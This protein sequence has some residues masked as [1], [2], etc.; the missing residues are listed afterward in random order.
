MPGRALY[1]VTIVGLIATLLPSSRAG[2]EP[3]VYVTDFANDSVVVIDT[4]TDTV[5]TS[6]DIGSVGQGIAFT[7]DG[8]TAYVPMDSGDIAVIDVA[9]NTVLTNIF[10]G[11]TVLGLG[12]IAITPDGTTAYVAHEGINSVVVLDTA[13]N[14]VA[15]TILVGSTPREIAISRDGTTAYVGDRSSGDVYL[16]DVA[17]NTVATTVS[18]GSS[19]YGIAVTP[20]GAFV[21]VTAAVGSSVEVID[22]STNTVIK[23]IPVGSFPRTIAMTPDGAFVYAAN[24]TAAS[25]SVIDTSSNT[26]VTTVAVGSSPRGIAVT[27]DGASVYVANSVSGSVSVIDTATN[28]TLTAVATGGVPLAVAIAPQ[29]ELA[30]I[31][32]IADAS[33]DGVPDI[34]GFIEGT[35]GRPAIAAYSGAD[36]TV[37]ATIDYINDKWRG[38]A[39]ATVRDADQD[40][41]DDDPAAAMLVVNKTTGKIRVETRRVDTG[42][43][44]G[45]I[46]FFN[47]NWRAVDVVA[48]DD[49]NGDGSTNDTAIAVLAERISDGRIQLQLRDYTAGTLISNTVYLNARW[50][51]IAT[52]VVDRTEVAPAG[53]LSPLIGVIAEKPSDGRR[54]MQSRV[55]GSG[56]FERNVKFLGSTWDYLDMSVNHDANSDGTN[57]DPIWIVLAT[58]PSD[59]VIR[60]Q[61][62][63]VSDGSFDRNIVIL[64]SGWEAFR[65]DAANDMG[66]NG[67]GEMVISAERR[68]DDVRRIHVKDYASSATTLNIAP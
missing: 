9:S 27:P 24:N 38:A 16:I 68:A 67:S 19:A 35:A 13:T 18:V 65:L 31:S 47:Q 23:S 22:T 7:P 21:Y 58:R 30:D 44:L 11:S 64:N 50:T 39:L 62:R 52:A 55:A 36:G 6:I 25:V 42:A 51:P 14:T 33:G 54:V 57:D 45:S 43:F 17:S 59:D 49:L 40:G 61:S 63:F 37:F 34:T 26:V 2:A 10:S 32:S 29:S 1:A 48:V 56:A 66:G 60:V 5:I 8:D 3:V 12:G 46:Q 53:T 20:D 4:A 28:T 41:T 15:T